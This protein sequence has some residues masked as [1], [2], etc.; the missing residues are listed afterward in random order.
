MRRIAITMLAAL[1]LAGCSQPTD[2]QP[3]PEGWCPHIPNRQTQQMEER[4]DVC[5]RSGGHV[6]CGDGLPPPAP[7]DHLE[8]YQGYRDG[9]LRASGGPTPLANL[10]YRAAVDEGVDPVVALRLVRVES[11]FNP[12][13]VSWAGAVGLA[14]VM[15]A[16]GRW[17]CGVSRNELFDPETNVSCGLRYYAYLKDMYG[18]RHMAVHAYNVGPGNLNAGMRNHK[19][20]RMVMGE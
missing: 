5:R 1:L 16:T 13:A 20:A 17:F 6:D 10:V 9:L 12:R 4:C 7:T 18:S 14:Q 8:R 3:E 15:P 19:Y 2:P 11:G